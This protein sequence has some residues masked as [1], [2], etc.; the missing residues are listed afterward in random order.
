MM[1]GRKL[2]IPL[3]QLLQMGFAVRL[4]FGNPFGFNPGLRQTLRY[5]LLRLRRNLVDRDRLHWL[6]TRW[7]PG[8]RRKS[9]R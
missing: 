1:P 2:V 3:R 6:A 7:R 5:A 9:A 8:S 4:V